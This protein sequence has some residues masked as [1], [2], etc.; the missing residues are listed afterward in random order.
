MAGAYGGGMVFTGV[1]FLCDFV[2]EVV[3]VGHFVAKNGVGFGAGPAA[4]EFAGFARVGGAGGN[5]KIV[6]GE[7]RGDLLLLFV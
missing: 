6:S 4:I 5:V 3:D 2:G 1:K 7:L